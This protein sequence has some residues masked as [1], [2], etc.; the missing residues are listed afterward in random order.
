MCEQKICPK[1]LDKLPEIFDIIYC[2]K[3][4]EQL[5]TIGMAISQATD[6]KASVKTE[7]PAARRKTK[8]R[9]SAPEIID[10][11]DDDNIPGMYLFLYKIEK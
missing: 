10:L 3:H 1:N 6:S 9:K 2:K 4:L 8:Q 11:S 7:T 5:A